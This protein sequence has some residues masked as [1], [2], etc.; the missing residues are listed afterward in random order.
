MVAR[1]APDDPRL[2]RRQIAERWGWVRPVAPQ[3]ARLVRHGR[4]CEAVPPLQWRG[5]E[6][7]RVAARRRP[8]TATGPIR[9]ASTTAPE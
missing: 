8:G 5:G 2:T 1:D 7:E 3:G 6:L 9:A 4:S